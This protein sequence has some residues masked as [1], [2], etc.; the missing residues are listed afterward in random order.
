MKRY[1]MEKTAKNDDFGEKNKRLEAQGSKKW[2][3]VG[4]LVGLF[5]V[6]ILILISFFSRENGIEVLTENS[7]EIKILENATWNVTTGNLTG[8]YNVGGIESNPQGLAF[9]DSGHKMYVCG[10]TEDQF[11]EYNLTESWNISTA[12]LVTN[13]GTNMSACVGIHFKSDGLRM[14]ASNGAKPIIQYDLSDAWNITSAVQV[15]I[16]TTTSGDLEDLYVNPDGNYL[17]YLESIGKIYRTTL[18]T[19]YDITTGNSV[20]LLDISGTEANTL[21]ISFMENGSKMYIVGANDRI[22]EY[23][24]STAWDLSTA[25]LVQNKD[26]SGSILNPN[27]IRFKTDGSRMF[28]L[29][30]SDDKVKQYYLSE[31]STGNSPTVTLHSPNNNE[32]LTR[33]NISFNCSATDDFIIN[34]IS[35]YL[36]ETLNYTEENGVTNFTELNITLN[37][38]NGAHNWTCRSYDNDTRQGNG[39]YRYFNISSISEKAQIF[40]VYALERSSQQFLI[41]VSYDSST[42]NN[43]QAILIYNN[44]E[45][46][47]T[48]YGSG[49]NVVFNKTITVPD[50]VSKTNFTFYWKVILG[51]NEFKFNS[52]FNNQTVSNLIIGKCDNDNTFGIY[53]F[54]IVSEK[55][56]AFINGTTH[57]SSAEVQIE[58]YTTNRNTL[59]TNY[60]TNFSKINPFSVCFNN[61][62]SSEQYSLDLQLIYSA[63]EYA[64]EYYHIQNGTISNSSLAQNITL[65]DLENDSSTIFKITYKDDNFLPV[66]NA[67]VQI[68]RKYT[69]EGAFKTVEI[70]KT[71]ANGETLAH[72]EEEDVIYS[73]IIVKNSVILAT[74]NNFLVKCEDPVLGKCNIQLNAYK[75]HLEPN[76]FENLNDFSFTL[77]YNITTKEVKS[78]FSIPSGST[79]TISL[80]TTLYD[81]LGNI[82]VCS[83][84]LTSA[85]GTLSCSIP[86][87]YGN[88]TVV[89]QLYK[90]GKIVG[91]GVFSAKESSKELFSGGVMFLGFFL[92]VTLI[93]MGIGSSPVVLGIFLILGAILNVALN[94]TDTTG[95]I[96]AGATILWIIVAI[97]III[98]KGANRE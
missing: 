5:L 48:K 24:L 57:N 26:V 90:D 13:T 51:D 1:K 96:G 38:A 60:S 15:A 72:L 94:L 8:E 87:S 7:K 93:G 39:T 21:G 35:L 20:V 49:S 86:N 40:N 88:T 23:G 82:T 55:T 3:V 11:I 45:Y 61:S 84:I 59:I 27:S 4:I 62:L 22:Y 52:T 85:S 30:T 25:V 34:N 17:F 32:V 37:I 19:P 9:S 69:D 50:V 56:Q 79:S 29:S 73:F 83:D 67:L 2:V 10:T 64:K 16:N 12:D 46:S 44:S 43:I 42:Y 6:S 41:N 91:R 14:W 31:A 77:E 63:N 98:I 36:D 53:N 97:I 76:D 18:V 33:E 95:I 81:G 58:L 71:D 78:I 68:Q 92:I 80:N 28:M 66:G 89:S 75:S 65:Y 74:F 70:P 47:G 54:T